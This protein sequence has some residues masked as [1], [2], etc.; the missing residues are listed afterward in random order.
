M[1]PELAYM[2]RKFLGCFCQIRWKVVNQGRQRYNYEQD[3]KFYGLQHTSKSGGC[4]P[5]P[6]GS[7]SVSRNCLDWLPAVPGAGL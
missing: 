6:C 1:F 7:K 5:A 2:L 3:V 4:L